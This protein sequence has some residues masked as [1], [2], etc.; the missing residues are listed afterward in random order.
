MASGEVDPLFDVRTTYYVGNF[1]QCI[2]EA[3][4]F[5]GPAAVEAKG[6]LYRAYVAQGQYGVVLSEINDSAPLELRAV[7]TLALYLQREA[8][9]DNAVAAATKLLTDPSA[10]SNPTVNVILATLFAQDGD[11]DSAL[12]ALH[13]TPASL[14]CTALAVQIL[15]RMD[16]V[17]LA[18]K[19]L[20]RMQEIDDDH[21]LTQLSNAWVNLHTGGDK[22]QDAFYT[23][24]EMTEKFGPSV[25]LL[26]GQ[27]SCLIL[28]NKFAEA[29]PILQSALEKSGGDPETLINLVVASQQLG[30]QAELV[31]RYLNQL[32]DVAPSHP[33][34]RDIAAKEENFA[35]QAAT[36]V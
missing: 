34:V 12:R 28:Q 11:T 9:R 32:R 6:Y 19:E 3:Q 15:L 35:R 10:A 36:I 13:E 22:Y 8:N 14:E 29:E 2:K 18:R 26:N 20:K 33:F 31:S 5:R 27:A 24:Q 30:R 21:T 1:S 4:N 16:R 25:F 17:D 23:F 7:R